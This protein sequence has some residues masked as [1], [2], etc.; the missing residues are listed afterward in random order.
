MDSRKIV[1]NNYS[2]MLLLQKKSK[3]YELVS[4]G[5]K[6]VTFEKESMEM[7][8][9]EELHLDKMQKVQIG[10]NSYAFTTAGMGKVQ[11]ESLSK[12]F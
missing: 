8:Q 10:L 2:T 11:T 4:K 9:F 3:D 7:Q 6:N 1:F 5:C 12:T